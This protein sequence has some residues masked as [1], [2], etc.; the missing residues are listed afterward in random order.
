MSAQPS[1][2]PWTSRVDDKEG[3][4]SAFLLVL[5]S[6]V[7]GKAQSTVT[8]VVLNEGCTELPLHKNSD[9]HLSQARVGL[10]TTKLATLVG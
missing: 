10:K 9:T 1:P 2:W 7:I 3:G 5:I 4:V 8:F 6:L